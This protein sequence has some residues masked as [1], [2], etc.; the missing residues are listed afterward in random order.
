MLRG[1]II[2]HLVLPNGV[3]GSERVMEW[4][5]QNLPRDTYVN[6]MAQYHPDYKASG[7]PELSRKITPGSIRPLWKGPGGSGFRIWMS[8]NRG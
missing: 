8:R 6:I 7:H 2:R 1:L 4:I 3:S 5:A